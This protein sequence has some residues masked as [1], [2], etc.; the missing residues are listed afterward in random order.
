VSWLRK[1]SR[2][3]SPPVP[4]ARKLGMG[5]TGIL[6][7]SLTSGSSIDVYADYTGTLTEAIIKNPQLK[8]QQEI[9][10]ALARLDLVM[11]QPLGF[12]QYLC[13]G[14][15]QSRS[16]GRTEYGPSATL[17]VEKT[18]SGRPSA[19]SS[20]IAP[21]ATRGWRRSITST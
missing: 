15:A 14:G 18:P 3:P 4:V 20:W 16:P 2:R 1:P 6:F 19:T 17:R 21:T 13:A 8:S 11:S 12:K 10:D 7:E 9:Q 5:S